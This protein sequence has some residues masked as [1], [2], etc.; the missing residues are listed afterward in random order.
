MPATAAP[1]RYSLPF[2]IFLIPYSAL[3]IYALFANSGYFTN[4]FF[5]QAF[6]VILIVTILAV[7]LRQ[8]GKFV[9]RTEKIAVN[10]GLYLKNLIESE[11]VK[12]GQSVIVELTD[13]YDYLSVKLAARHFDRILFDRDYG[14]N[15]NSEFIAMDENDIVQYL[16][17]NSAKYV[18]ARND[19]IKARLGNLNFVHKIN[20]FGDWEIYSVNLSYQK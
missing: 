13:N 14:E 7:N 9:H 18:A 4:A 15:Q 3:G 11:T 5:R 10:V 8:S 12:R 6:F 1:G 17:K 2:I 19:S 20:Q 16:N